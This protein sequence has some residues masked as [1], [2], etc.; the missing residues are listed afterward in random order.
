MPVIIKS[1]FTPMT[2][3]EIT[4]PLLQQT[5]AQQAMEDSYLEAND[6]ASKLMALAN[7]QT[8]PIAYN[9]LKNYADDLK[10]QADNLVAKG[11]QT[12][13]RQALLNMKRRYSSEINP[14]EIAAARREELSKEQRDAL[15][16]DQSLRFS[17]DYRTASLDSMLNNAG[18][19]YTALSGAQIAKDTATMASMYV[20]AIT[21]DPVYSKVLNGQYWQERVQ[22]GYTPSQILAE[23]MG[24]PNAPAELKGIRESIH[25]QISGS[26]AYDRTWADSYINQG[27]AAAIGKETVDLVNNQNFMSEA[28][29]RRIALDEERLRL[30]QP[31]SAD[32]RVLTSDGTY[33]DPN[34]GLIYDGNTDDSKVILTKKS[35]TSTNT[36]T[37]E[38]STDDKKKIL[39]TSPTVY[40]N[41]KGK[42]IKAEDFDIENATKVNKTE[43][44]A[45][46][47]NY[48]MSVLNTYG[49]T[50]DDVDIY[51]DNDV[52][53]YED[54]KIVPQGYEVTGSE[55]ITLNGEG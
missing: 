22:R 20:D 44:P 54:Y 11:L 52:W 25:N 30:S 4:K 41:S 27:M 13:S 47:M 38:L 50:L 14:I 7:Q 5:E 12:G 3:D 18:A 55:T 32:K 10:V 35:T 53:G 39:L 51:R 37:T 16:K 33:L 26:E 2:Y 23:A 46:R 6:N 1:A 15:L 8:D 45:T 43:I 29:R 49:L 9:R 36:K 40:F 28:E 48:I 19:S 31:V 24:D 34:T 42:K 17:T 21:N